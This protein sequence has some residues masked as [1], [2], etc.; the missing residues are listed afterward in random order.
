MKRF[1]VLALP[2]L[3]LLT[4]GCGLG[5]YVSNERTAVAPQ[6]PNCLGHL[7]QGRDYVAQERY[8]LAKE[9][10]LMAVAACDDGE[11]RD[12]ATKELK[13]VDMMIQTQR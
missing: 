10:Y 11:G 6:N 8:E 9:Q 12:V 1:A 5:S 4:G 7:K 2:C 13:A 3:L